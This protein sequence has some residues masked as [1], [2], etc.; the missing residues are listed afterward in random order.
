MKK[1]AAVAMIVGLITVTGCGTTEDVGGGDNVERRVENIVLNDGRTVTCVFTS[2]SYRSG[3]SC[4]W[5]SIVT[6][7]P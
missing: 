6:E 2:D 5:E 7:T 3:V 4:D 1:L